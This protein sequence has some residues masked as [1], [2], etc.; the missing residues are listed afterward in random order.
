MRPQRARWGAA[1]GW[2]RRPSKPPD[3]V[4]A[5]DSQIFTHVVLHHST[6]SS[7]P[8]PYRLMGLSPTSCYCNTMQRPGRVST[9]APSFFM[10]ENRSA[11]HDKLQAAAALSPV[12]AP[13][14]AMVAAQRRRRPSCLCPV[15]DERQA[16]AA[17]S[18][19]AA[20]L[21][22]MVAVQRRRLRPSCPCPLHDER[23]AAAALS[24]C[25]AP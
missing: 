16:A 8:A 13:S 9:M 17:L 25:A 18:P 11:V 22:A 5:P 14:A 19:C 2:R 23:Q 15:H 21:A 10:P 3:S 20:P 6:T 7:A 4:A 12:A 1:A 24:P